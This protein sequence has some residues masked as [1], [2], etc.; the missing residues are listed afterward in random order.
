MKDV[1]R[2]FYEVR[3]ELSRVIW[4][5][6]DEFVG[7]TIIALMI[8]AFFSVYLGVIDF[9]LSQLANYAFARFGMY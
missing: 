1:A 4:P 7:S 2:F 5:S 3:I 8:I 9:G 6:R